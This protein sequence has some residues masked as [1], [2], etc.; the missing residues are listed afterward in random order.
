MSNLYFASDE[1]A[2]L[3]SNTEDDDAHSGSNVYQNTVTTAGE[4]ILREASKS[5]MGS[6]SNSNV[7]TFSARHA[8]LTV[9]TGT[10]SG[11]VWSFLPCNMFTQRNARSG[12]AQIFIVV[13]SFS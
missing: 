9:Q 13:D 8:N 4:C 7:Q 1:M 10:I 2:R 5:Y 11:A 3:E 12:F 6:Q